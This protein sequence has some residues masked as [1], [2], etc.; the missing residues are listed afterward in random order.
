MQEVTATLADTRP[1]C[2]NCF[3]SHKKYLFW[4]KH[5]K[6]VH[7]AVGWVTTS[8]LPSDMPS[9]TVCAPSARPEQSDVVAESLK[10]LKMQEE[11]PQI[12]AAV[13]H[14]LIIW[15]IIYERIMAPLDGPSC[16]IPSWTW[17]AAGVIEL[18]WE[19]DNN[20]GMMCCQIVAFSFFSFF[21]LLNWAWWVWDSFL[22]IWRASCALP[23]ISNERC[24][25]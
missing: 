9:E 4:H 2:E 18:E 7:L 20:Y 25:S 1:P 10:W 23:N 22:A 5:V 24:V 13:F 12:Y 11:N 14:T 8:T 16:W 6:H 3:A 21:L 17:K 15:W 19:F